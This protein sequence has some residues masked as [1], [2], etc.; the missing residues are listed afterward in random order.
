VKDGKQGGWKSGKAEKG[1]LM[2]GLQGFT[3]AIAFCCG[4]PVRRECPAINTN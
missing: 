2:W 1:R 3:C 4:H